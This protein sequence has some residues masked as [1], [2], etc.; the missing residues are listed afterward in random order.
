[1]TKPIV[2]LNEVLKPMSRAEIDKHLRRSA[3]LQREFLEA[4][5]RSA[6]TLEGVANQSSLKMLEDVVKQSPLQTLEDLVNKSSLK[7]LEEVTQPNPAEKLK[8]YGMSGLYQLYQS[9]GE[10]GK[11][12]VTTIPNR[13]NVPSYLGN[14]VS[15]AGK[16]D[17]K[18]VT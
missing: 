9:V 3:E 4:K 11:R 6:S 1:M 17:K 15:K 8:N 18:K 5:R 12:Y 7:T 13:A 14:S 16:S 10:Q 2:D